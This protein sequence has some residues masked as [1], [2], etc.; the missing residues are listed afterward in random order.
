MPIFSIFV[1]LQKNKIMIS[2]DKHVVEEYNNL[3]SDKSEEWRRIGAVGKA[4]NII[5]LA[6]S[7]SF[8]KVVEIGAGDGNLLL[9]LSEEKFGN[10]LTA[11]E[12]SDSA[13]NQIKK[14][15]INNLKEVV[16]FDGYQL[17]FKDKEFDL[18]ICSH[19]IE[20]VEHPRILLRE[21]KRI[22]NHQI[23]EVPIDFS[24]FVDK[25][26]KHFLSYGHINIYTPSLFKFL[27]KSEGF[28]IIKERYELYDKKVVQFQQKD[29]FKLSLKRLILK[30][31]PL[32]MKIK[33][34]TYTVLTNDT[35]ENIKIF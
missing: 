4:K 9:K 21:I 10:E 23:F 24:F 8:K 12:I 26:V 14:K 33:P 32:L 5:K 22:S 18:A 16:K 17:P 19:V 27:L 29:K 2:I 11:A 13:I 25:K 15:N 20:H 35:N 1:F 3:Y 6:E 31:I 28:N 34:N 7:F 30:A